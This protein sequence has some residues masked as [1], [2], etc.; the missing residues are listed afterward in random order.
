MTVMSA[1]GSLLAGTIRAAETV[2]QLRKL[3]V[4]EMNISVAV[5]LVGVK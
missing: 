3:C 2:K 4:S 5:M 1:E